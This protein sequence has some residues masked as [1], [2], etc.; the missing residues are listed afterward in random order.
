MNE[1]VKTLRIEFW[2]TLFV[3]LVM[4]VLFETSWLFD[5]HGAYVGHKNAEFLLS[6][7]MELVTIAIIPVD[8]RFHKIKF[9]RRFMSVEGKELKRRTYIFWRSRMALLFVPI[10]INTLLYYLFMQTTFGY[11]AIILAICLVFTYPYA[12]IDNHSKL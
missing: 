3:I 11:L 12:T 2:V 8:L 10:V 5:G 1:V 4:V 6:S 9:I 7:L